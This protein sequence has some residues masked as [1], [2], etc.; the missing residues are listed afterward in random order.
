MRILGNQLVK[1]K[2][3]I[4]VLVEGVRRVHQV[5]IAHHVVPDMDLGTV[6]H[7]FWLLHALTVD[8]RS[9]ANVLEIHV[10]LFPLNLEL[11]DSR[12]FNKNVSG[13]FCDI[14]HWRRILDQVWKLF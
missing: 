14:G 2:L 11:G 7:E 1:R 3:S 13:Q 9:D 12:L 5:R 8:L 6:W 4:S 10:F